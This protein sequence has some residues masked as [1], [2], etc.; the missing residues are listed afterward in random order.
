MNK[1]HFVVLPVIRFNKADNRHYENDKEDDLSNNRNPHNETENQLNNQQNKTLLGMELGELGVTPKNKRE[2]AKKPGIGK[3]G[4][5]PIG[6]DVGV[7]HFFF[8]DGHNL[9]K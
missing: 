5:E 7:V 6:F 1:G 9:K 8:L 4:E 3:S 2:Q